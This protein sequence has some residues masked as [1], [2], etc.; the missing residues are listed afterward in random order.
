M[1]GEGV[2]RVLVTGGAGFIGSH[3]VDALVR[4][5]Y[6]VKVLDDLSCGDLDNIGVHL[7]SGLVEFFEGDIR[8]RGLVEEVLAGVDAVVHLAALVS[9]PLSVED[10]E[11]TF[12]VNVNGTRNVVASCASSGVKKLVFASSCAVYGEAQYLPINEAHPRRPLSPYASSKLEGERV[13]WNFAEDSDADVAILRFF[14]VYGPRQTTGDY[15]GV[16]TKF[17]DWAEKGESLVVYGD[18]SQTRDFVYVS[19]VAQAILMLLESRSVGGV[20]N[21]GYGEAVT[22]S[23]LALKIIALVGKDVGV[24]YRP[25]RKGDIRRS[26]ADISKARK[27]FGFSPRVSLDEGLRRLLRWREGSLR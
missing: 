13:C 14:N 6:S 10:P 15:S 17:F 1:T 25:P 18:G 24:V 26:L 27:A 20:F 7:R 12:D 4:S 19:D 23:D 11:F 9:V 3:V 8:D 2:H 22:I 5:G 16:I 21:I